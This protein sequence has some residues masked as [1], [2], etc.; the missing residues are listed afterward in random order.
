MTSTGSTLGNCLEK[1]RASLEAWNKIEF[2]HVGRKVAELQKR[3]EWIELQPSSPK[4]NNELMRTRADLN[5]WL[6]KEDDM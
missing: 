3:L 6:D 4:I 2:G 1:C 5:C